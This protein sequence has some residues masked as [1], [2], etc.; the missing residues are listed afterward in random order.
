MVT[1]YAELYFFL[2]FCHIFCA[3]FDWNNNGKISIG[4][5][6]VR[7]KMTEL[8][9]RMVMTMIKTMVM[10]MTVLA[11]VMTMHARTMLRMFLMP[12]VMRI[13]LTIERKMVKMI[14]MKPGENQSRNFLHMSITI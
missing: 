14:L 4:S 12:M 8:I 11:V 6:Q 2:Q 7:L 9:K 13:V 1:S 5:L 10:T 3:A